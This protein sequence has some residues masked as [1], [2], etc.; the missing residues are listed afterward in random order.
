MA[1]TIKQFLSLPEGRTISINVIAVM[2]LAAQESAPSKTVYITCPYRPP[3]P[4]I[5]QQ[6]SYKTGCVLIA[7]DKPL[8]QPA[9]TQE[10]ISSYAIY[11]DGQWHGEVKANRIGDNQGYQFFLTD[12]EPE[13]SYDIAVKVRKKYLTAWC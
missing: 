12:L 8:G 10:A 5:A 11:V 2:T 6:P 7:W 13:Q 3:V 4:C 9:S 1:P